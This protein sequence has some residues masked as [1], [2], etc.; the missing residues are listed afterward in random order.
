MELNEI[1]GFRKRGWAARI[2]DWIASL[3]GWAGYETRCF[4][5]GL[6]MF[7][8]QC[9]NVVILRLNRATVNALEM[10]RLAYLRRDG[11]EIVVPRSHHMNR[12]YYFR[13]GELPDV[14]FVQR[15]NSFHLENGSSDFFD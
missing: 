4:L 11:H 1:L 13:F 7:L 10:Q 3:V 15:E 2:L 8:R 9:L 12:S 14:K 6:Q 5:R